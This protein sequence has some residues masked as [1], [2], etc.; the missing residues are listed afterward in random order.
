MNLG[1]SLEQSDGR[2]TFNCWHETTLGELCDEEL[3]E[4]QTGPFGSQLHASDYK[5]SGIPVVNPTHLRTN[6]IDETHLPR[7]D[8]ADADRLSRHYLR[9]G[10]ILI[11]RRGDF[12]RYSYIGPH[13]SGWLCG[14]G[15]LLIRLNHPE[16]NN[17]F[18]AYLM[19]FDIVQDY[20]REAAVGSIMPNLNTRILS[21]MPVSFPPLREQQAIVRLLDAVR[22]AMDVRQ[23]ELSLERERKAALMEY[24]FTHGTRGEQSKQTEIGEIPKNWEVTSLAD[25]AQI[26]SGGTP[27]RTRPD[28]WNGGIPWAKTGE[29]RYDTIH[30][31]DETISQAGLD[32]SAAKIIPA[33]T[34]LMAMYGQGITRG[35]VAI[36]GIDATL[37]QACAAILLS[38]KIVTRFAFFYLQFAYERIRTLGHGA[39]QKNLNAQLVGSIQIPI[40]TL[41]EQEAICRPLVALD[42]KLSAL[43]RECSLLD[44]LFQA[45]LEEL[46]TGRLSTVPLIEEHQPK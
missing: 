23:R 24:L 21:E 11:S 8:K 9:D 43:E 34:L 35:K 30:Q 29:I 46:M 28:Y 6:A 26:T 40:P 32:N 4:I 36:L 1:E 33:G 39:N 7:I 14:T 45:T 16:V 13:Q 25:V 10:D 3:G 22:S 27:D 38:G 37:N 41:E 44:E 19:S 17:R 2:S 20:L 18:L 5:P 42:A 15:C 31:T 12:S